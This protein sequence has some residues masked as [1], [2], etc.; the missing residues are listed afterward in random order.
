MQQIEKSSAGQKVRKMRPGWM[1]QPLQTKEWLERLAR[2]GLELE[3]VTAAVFTFRE[4][5]PKLISY[6]VNFEPKVNTDFYSFHQ[7][8]R[9]E[10]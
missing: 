10:T 3:S 7:D 8:I 9:L 1:Y 5:N 4:T 6:E 2:E